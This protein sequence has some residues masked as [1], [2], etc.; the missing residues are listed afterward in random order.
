MVNAC[1][2]EEGAEVTA[3]LRICENCAEE[4]RALE[5]VVGALAEAEFEH[6]YEF[7]DEFE[8]APGSASGPAARIIA[9]ALPLR[10]PAPA[11]PPWARPYPMQ[12]ATLDAVLAELAPDDWNLTVVEGWTVTELL[13]HL[14][15][16]DSLLAD[17]V[18]VPRAALAGAG[19]EGVADPG[20]TIPART[21]AF[22]DAARRLGPASVRA[23]WSGQA[24]ALCAALT[25]C[26]TPSREVSLGPAEIS[27]PLADQVLGR[28]FETW[29]HT[30]DIAQRIG[31]TLPPPVPEA[32]EPMADLGARLLDLA[33]RTTAPESPAVRLVLTGEC[34][35]TRLVGSGEPAAELAL[36]VLEFCFLAGG[37]RD[38]VRMA[39]EVRIDGD[40]ALAR[41]ALVAAA[42]FARP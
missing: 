17:A 36:D 9:A 37:R 1:T 30:A 8:P 42:A 38:P 23:A 32:L 41:R 2:Q 14:A 18:D 11:V 20:R 10:R 29:L 21:A 5:S 25:D 39:D 34:G 31:R 24:E 27:V 12:V 22:T 35:S 16:T 15:A 33:L 6:D 26:D 19:P 7:E 3:H 13:A 40:G 4:V 28:G